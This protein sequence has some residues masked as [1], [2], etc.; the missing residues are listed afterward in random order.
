KHV[1]LKYSTTFA[2]QNQCFHSAE[3]TSAWHFPFSTDT[4]EGPEAIDTAILFVSDIEASLEEQRDGKT[5]H[6]YQVIYT[7]EEGEHTG[8]V[9]SEGQQHVSLHSQWSWPGFDVVDNTQLTLDQYFAR[10]M[11]AGNNV[12]EEE[13]ST[14][15]APAQA[16]ETG[17]I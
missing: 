1:R 12:T 4:L 15:Q 3:N 10:H 7:T 9:C 6:W 2:Q 17:P 8:W 11:L 16:V 13:K 5:I 14:F